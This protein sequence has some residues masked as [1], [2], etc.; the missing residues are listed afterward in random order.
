MA[1]GV[2]VNSSLAKPAGII[3]AAG[4]SSRMGRDKAL[5]PFRGAT[6]LNH[7]ISVLLPRV[8][9]L[10]V[11]L[12]HHAETIRDSMAAGPQVAVNPDYKLGMLSSLQAGIRALPP[13]AEAALFTLVDHPAVHESTVD[14]LLEAFR[15][16]AKPLVIPC[17]GERR[18]HPVIASCA[19]LDEMLDL[20]PDASPKDV[21]RAHRAETHL[22]DVD[23]PGILRDIDLPSDYEKLNDLL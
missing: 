11:V 9:P 17:Y 6:F 15:T 20:T 23:D 18:G 19:V 5:L 10:I 12:G 1:S 13:E 14:Q 16:S 7:L 4:E 22:V 2:L 3:L 8:Q 21:I